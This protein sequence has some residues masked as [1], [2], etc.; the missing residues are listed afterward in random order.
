MQARTLKR[1]TPH[2]HEGQTRKRF[3]ASFRSALQTHLQG[4]DGATPEVVI[5]KCR[6][7]AALLS[8]LN[9]VTFRQ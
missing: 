4:V 6:H 3:Y 2:G 8:R 5:N 9:D 1:S 7:D